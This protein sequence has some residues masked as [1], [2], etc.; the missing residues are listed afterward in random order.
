MYWLGTFLYYDKTSLLIY[1]I[2]CIIYIV[3]CFMYWTKIFWIISIVVAI[4]VITMLGVSF[5]VQS[6][7]NIKMN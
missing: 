1:T 5:V 6:C 3:C 7:M 2:F 4:F